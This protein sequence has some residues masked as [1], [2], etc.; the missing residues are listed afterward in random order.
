MAHG[1]AATPAGGNKV[2]AGG[3]LLR[4]R[5]SKRRY[6]RQNNSKGRQKEKIK[7]RRFPARAPRRMTPTANAAGKISKLLLFLFFIL[8][9]VHVPRAGGG[10][11][12]EIVIG[13][14]AGFRAHALLET[15]ERSLG[16]FL[17]TIASGEYVEQ[18]VHFVF[19]VVHGDSLKSMDA[20]KGALTPRE[21]PKTFDTFQPFPPAA[22]TITNN[23]PSLQ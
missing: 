1:A 23:A 9:F 4:S 17:R 15:V 2:E 22:Y 6:I 12:V 21:Q 5:R 16:W 11:P 19:L 18:F 3:W 8:G 7:A 13:K 10:Q 20:I 14:H